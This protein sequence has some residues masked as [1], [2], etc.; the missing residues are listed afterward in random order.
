MIR[1]NQPFILQDFHQKMVFIGG[2][3]QVGKTTLSRSLCQGDFAVSVYLNWN[4]RENLQAIL[5][6]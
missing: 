1:Y 3:R 5:K 4:S 6:K 2:P